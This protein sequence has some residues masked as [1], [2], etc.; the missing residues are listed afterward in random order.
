MSNKKTPKVQIKE[1]EKVK[2]FLATLEELV[3]L[4]LAGYKSELNLSPHQA[5][6]E[7]LRISEEIVLTDKAIK[8][9]ESQI[10]KGK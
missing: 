6:G 4:D 2:S 9:F 8:G 7:L 10:D 5:M 1:L 3:I